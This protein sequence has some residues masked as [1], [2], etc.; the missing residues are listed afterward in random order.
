MFGTVL[1]LWSASAQDHD[2]EPIVP[3][4]K[5]SQPTLR[6][7]PFSHEETFNTAGSYRYYCS[8]HGGADWSGMR[9]EVVVQ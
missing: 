5:P 1:F 2:I 7:G 4:T 3:G 6:D 9:G 8:A